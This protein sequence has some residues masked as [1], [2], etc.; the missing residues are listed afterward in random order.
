MSVCKS[1]LSLVLLYETYVSKACRTCCIYKGIQ[2]KQS[3][4]RPNELPFQYF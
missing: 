4:S 3:G 1:K 2:L